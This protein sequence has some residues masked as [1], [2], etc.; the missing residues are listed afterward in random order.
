MTIDLVADPSL[1]AQLAKHVSA[2]ACKCFTNGLLTPQMREAVIS[3]LYKG[4][5]DRDLCKSHRPVS[6]TDVTCRIIDKALQLA[7]NDVVGTVLCGVNI[8]F[9]ERKREKC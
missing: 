2:L 9:L 4:K 5:G 6:L 7:L 3:I 1:R 8:A